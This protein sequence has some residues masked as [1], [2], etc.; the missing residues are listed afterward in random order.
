[1]WF[2][3]KKYFIKLIKKVGFYRLSFFA[4][5][6][7][8]QKKFSYISVSKYRGVAKF[9]IALGL[10]PRNRR[11]EPCRPDQNNRPTTGGYLWGKYMQ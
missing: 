3:E 11:F 2:Y 9:G 1:M 4:K 6:A 7:N 5:R 10:G 8:L